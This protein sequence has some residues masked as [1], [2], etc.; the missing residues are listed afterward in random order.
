MMQDLLEKAAILEYLNSDLKCW[1]KFIL[2]LGSKGPT[3]K[4]DRV[5]SYAQ[6]VPSLH[7]ELPVIIV[8]LG[9]SLCINL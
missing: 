8:T 3:S 1:I 5:F 7:A 6:M 9:T 4:L 2:H